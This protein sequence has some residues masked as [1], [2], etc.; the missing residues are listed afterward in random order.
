M[1]G[2]DK[3]NLALTFFLSVGPPVCLGLEGNL[4][5]RQSRRLTISHGLIGK[6]LGS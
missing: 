6:D 5:V 3:N 2:G 4:D 1:G